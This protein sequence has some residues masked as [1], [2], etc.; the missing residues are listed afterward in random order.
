MAVNPRKSYPD[1]VFSYG[2]L[3]N[4]KETGMFETSI[5][6]S[7]TGLVE[8][9]ARQTLLAGAPDPKYLPAY[10]RGVLRDF[11]RDQGLLNVKILVLSENKVHFDLAFSLE[12]LGNPPESEHQGIAEALG[13]FLPTHYSI[14]LISEKGLPDFTSL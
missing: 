9:K 5:P 13:W 4:F 6:V 1:Y 3:W 10:V 11:F 14:L 8:L 7:P 12:S 2:M